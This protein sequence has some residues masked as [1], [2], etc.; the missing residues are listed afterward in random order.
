MK[1]VS[2]V[3]ESYILS[4]IHKGWFSK[5][6][7]TLNTSKK[8]LIQDPFSQLSDHL[9][10][11][12]I[13][14]L[15]I[16]SLNALRVASYIALCSTN[17]D[18]FW[19]GHLLTSMPWFWELRNILEAAGT[20]VANHRAFYMWLHHE[21]QFIPG[22]P[23]PLL[24]LANRRRIWY[25]SE[26]IAPRYHHH[27]N[28]KPQ[29]AID[30]DISSNSRCLQRPSVMLE[31]NRDIDSTEKEREDIYFAHSWYEMHKMPTTFEVSYQVMPNNHSRIVGFGICYCETQR[32]WG[33]DADKMEFGADYYV[34]QAMMIPASNWITRMGF[35]IHTEDR[36]GGLFRSFI[37]A[38]EVKSSIHFCSGYDSLLIRCRYLLVLERL[39]I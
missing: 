34:K 35:R 2:S 19:K 38:I 12:I 26:Q 15:S 6:E 29:S 17:R 20:L 25:V 31:I 14:Y 21:T 22:V 10:Y 37:S 24:N 7:T 33:I 27:A 1:E 4:K 8:R 11:A 16:E 28:F 5:A 36:E 30:E 3:V 9:I 18:T 32:L 39:S 13:P 23:L